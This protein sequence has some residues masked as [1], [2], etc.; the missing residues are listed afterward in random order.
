IWPMRQ[1]G[2]IIGD[3]SKATVSVGRLDDV[4]CKSDE[5]VQEKGILKPEITGSVR[6]DNVSFRFAD[7]TYHQLEGISFAINKGETVAIIGKTGSGKSTLMNLLVRLLDYQEG[8]IYIDDYPITEIEKHYLRQNVGI[9]LQEPF[10]FSKTV[11][12]NIGIADR[13]QR[14]GPRVQEVAKIAR[15]HDDIVQFEKGY[16]TLVGERGVTL[17]GGQ[18]QRVAI[19]RMLLKPKPILIFDDSLSA[20]DTETDIQIREALKKEWKNSTVFIITHRITTA[21][22]AD[23]ILV[24]DQG[25]IVETGRHQDLI[26]TKGLYRKIWD[27]QSK[28]DF[29]LEGGDDHE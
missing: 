13:N 2:R 9:I 3:I 6:F 1:L 10:L 26:K 12:E 27:I 16:Q 21:K 7:S 17:S 23:R 8:T 14:G 11:E 20:V 29:Q 5:Y 28:I 15:V 18:K 19:A 25:K 24:L 4:L 22:E